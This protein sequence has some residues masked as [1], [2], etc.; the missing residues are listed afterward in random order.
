MT[1]LEILERDIQTSWES[2]RA[3]RAELADASISL[4]RRI[5]LHRNMEW[6]LEQLDWMLPRQDVL[7]DE[8][9]S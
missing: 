1:E 9:D 8:R 6:H 4:E 3:D 5:G 2:I 7:M